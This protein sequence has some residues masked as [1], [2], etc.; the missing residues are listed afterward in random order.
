[1]IRL[2]RTRPWRP[3]GATVAIVALAATGL[4]ACGDD[5]GDA[6]T[7][8]FNVAEKSISGP[9]S[10]DTGEA[11]ITLTNDGKQEADLQLIRVEGQHSAA[12]VVQ[13]VG[14]AVRGRALPDW[15]FAGGGVGLTQ[16]GQSQTVTQVLEP[17]TYYAFNTVGEGPPDPES[18][19]AIEVTG[20]P[21]DDELSDADAT[22]RTIDY[23]F[24][25]EGDL[26]VGENEI[27]FENAGAQPHHVIAQ[28]IAQGKTIED[29][30]A[31][32]ENQKG[33]PP[34]EETG[35]AETAILDAGG[36]QLVTLD[37]KQPGTYAMLCFISDRQGGPPHSIGEG[38]LGEFE[39]K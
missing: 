37:L 36:S 17:G 15:F 29:V 14:G 30:R 31:F 1:M 34:L 28:P 33:Q 8:S 27:T 4:V 13:A 12:E 7:L 22:V 6:Q 24:E 20:D 35:L 16:A 25:T 5:G 19:P 2:V 10:A 23:G 18:V 11:E 26:Q 39:V 21:S 32:L 3:A 38:M 9:T